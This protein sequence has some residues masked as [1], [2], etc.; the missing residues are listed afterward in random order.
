MGLLPHFLVGSTR[1]YWIIALDP[2]YRYAAVGPPVVAGRRA[3]P[4]CRGDGETMETN[5]PPPSA[6]T[7]TMWTAIA[8]APGIHRT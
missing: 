6:A 3:C 2:E 5:S 8:E 7:A 4:G 1:P